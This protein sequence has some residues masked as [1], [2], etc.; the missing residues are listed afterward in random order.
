[1]CGALAQSRR[2]GHRSLVTPESALSE[3]NKDLIFFFEVSINELLSIKIKLCRTALQANDPKSKGCRQKNY[4]RGANRRTIKTEQ[5][6]SR[7]PP[8]LAVTD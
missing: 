3:C 2:V 5:L 8:L 7:T 4:Q 1:M 6:A